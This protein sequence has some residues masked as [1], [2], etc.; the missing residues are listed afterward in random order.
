M[1]FLFSKH[2][3]I[4]LPSTAV[5][6]HLLLNVDRELFQGSDERTPPEIFFYKIL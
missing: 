3:Y 5:D 1:F 4:L 2:P 6:I